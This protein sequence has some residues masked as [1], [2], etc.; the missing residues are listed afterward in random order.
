MG[1]VAK[2]SD[3]LLKAQVKCIVDYHNKKVVS[4][5]KSDGKSL[6]GLHLRDKFSGSKLDRVKGINIGDRADVGNKALEM[7][8][9][10]DPWR[11]SLDR[12]Q[13]S[14]C[15]LRK[16]LDHQ[17]D[18][19]VKRCLYSPLSD[20]EL[21]LFGWNA[22]QVNNSKPEGE[23]VSNLV[24][25]LAIAATIAVLV[26]VWRI[27]RNGSAKQDEQELTV[28]P[29]YKALQE[30][31]G[32][33]GK[34]AE[35]AQKLIK[36]TKDPLV[37]KVDDSL[38]DTISTESESRILLGELAKQSLGIEGYKPKPGDP[39]NSKRMS[40]SVDMVDDGSLWVVDPSEEPEVGYERSGR[41][42]LK[43]RVKACTA[44]WWC[45]ACADPECKV[46]QAVLA[47]PEKYVGL[48]AE[49]AGEWSVR[50][51]F[52][53]FT[54]LREELDEAAIRGWGERFSARLKERYSDREDRELV[55]WGAQGEPYD[56][57]VMQTR[58]EPP[59]GDA[60]VE[61]VEE[62]GGQPQQ[63]LGCRGAPP[64]LYAVVRVREV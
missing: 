37:F 47:D 30:L 28:S 15:E 26:L 61:A 35:L 6:T 21:R 55:W 59:V 63:G 43:A 62:R 46:A 54:D 19:Y 58:G 22:G 42:L 50:L 27:R 12:L 49:Y 13:N 2:S 16:R 36:K 14:I 51:G 3:D 41:V 38:G 64:L 60:E 56:L 52:N 11:C 8:W 33:E 17:H 31:G 5:K 32:R 29:D 57:S 25:Y 34:V 7:F 45:L 18:G 20:E 4:D 39:F 48:D 10:I 44:D 9:D 1:D 53:T 40:S 24:V 23:G